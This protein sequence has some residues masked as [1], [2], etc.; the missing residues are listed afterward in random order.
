M[1]LKPIHDPNSGVLRV[2][3][4]MSGSGSNLRKILAHQENLR[5]KEGNYLFKMVVIFADN[6]ASKTLEIGKEY[7]LPVI[8]HDIG[9]FYKKHDAPRSD[10]KLR[11]QFDELTVRML[12]AFDVRVA[13]FG[14]Y[15]SLAT[16]ALVNAF[17]GVNVHPAD[18]SIEQNGKR[19]WTGGHA[20]LDQVASGAKTL[21][22][23]THLIEPECDMGRIFMVS[24]PLAIEIPAGL[25]PK[26]PAQLKQIADYNQERLKENGDWIIFPK[27][28]EEIARGNF[29]RDESG[30]FHYRGAPIPRGVRLE[31]LG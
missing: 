20:V 27:T 18:L 13:A 5:K 22:A 21:A 7:D 17:I 28:I 8:I 10:L 6:A 24:R 19:K 23:T 12:S 31:E 9:S 15:M 2:A 4:L 3:G 11:A 30:S 16:R 25:D 14:G 29:S 1:A 26:D